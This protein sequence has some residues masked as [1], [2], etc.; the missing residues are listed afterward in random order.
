MVGLLDATKVYVLAVIEHASRRV[1]VLGTTANP[2][3]NWVVQQSRNL[4]MDL[5]ETGTHARFLIHDR[6]A[7]FPAAFDQVLA[8]AGITVIRSAVRAPRMNGLIE[9]WF[10]SLRA[11]RTDRTLIWNIAYL[12]RL[13]R[14]YETFYN[15]HRPHPAL[16]QAAPR[17]FDPSPKTSSISRPSAC[18]GVTAPEAPPRRPAGRISFRHPQVSKNLSAYCPR[19][20]ANRC[21]E[22]QF[23][24]LYGYSVTKSINAKGPGQRMSDLVLDSSPDG[25]RTR[26]TA[27]REQPP[28]EIY[29]Q[30]RG[31][32]SML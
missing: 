24:A 14:E 20:A 12:R 1:R 7:S 19:L 28:E 23:M 8:D 21:P 5:Q 10:R 32:S 4:L 29:T 27:L 15:E 16:G 17:R 31:T 22:W 26:A 6:D 9:R 25:I 2:V 11:K 30:F 13:L 3:A 18:A